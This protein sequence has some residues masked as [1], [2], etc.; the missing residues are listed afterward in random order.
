MIAFISRM[1]AENSPFTAILQTNG[2]QARGVSLIEL[3]PI[4]WE[5]PRPT[6]W[7]FFSS[8]SAVLFFFEKNPPVTAQIAAIGPGT[9]ETLSAYVPHIHF[10]G[11]GDPETTARQF[12][13]LVAGQT[14]LFPGAQHSRQSIQ[15]LLGSHS[16]HIYLPIYDNVPVADPPA[17]TDAAVL[18]FT[19][20]LNAEAYFTRHALQPGQRVVAIG[21][22]TAKTL[23]ALGINKISTAK[24][25]SEEDM[26]RAVLEIYE[27]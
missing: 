24:M 15:T 27:T 9:A 7:I 1:L 22:P 12:G 25:P 11:N 21:Q 8:R 16:T 20:S 4:A 26:A 3:S 6:D 14:V 18:A 2:W 13:P 10:T 5:M 19:S 23:A 17:Q